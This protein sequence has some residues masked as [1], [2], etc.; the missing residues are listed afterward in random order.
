LRNISPGNVDLTGVELAGAVTHSLTGTPDTLTLPPGA[1]AVVAANPTALVAVHGA[2]PAGLRI[3][4]PFTGALN[5]A[6]ETVTVRTPSGAII[7]EYSYSP[8]APWPDGAGR[9]IVLQRPWTNPDHNDGHNWRSSVATRGTPYGSDSVPFSGN[10]IA[11]TDSDGFADGIE[12]SLGTVANSADSKPSISINATTEFVN[13][14]FGRYLRLT[15]RRSLLNDEGLVLPELSLSLSTWN[16]DAFAR[17]SQADHGDGTVTEIW[18]SKNPVPA[19]K[20][21]VRLRVTSP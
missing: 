19:E 15:F 14:A 6:G 7:K 21:F 20:A 4:G 2:A 17:I 5:N 12:Y 8:S 18:R 11:D 13:G 16:S 10:W 9:S 1:E 3:F